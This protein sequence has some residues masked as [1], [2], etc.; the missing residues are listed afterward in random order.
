MTIFLTQGVYSINVSASFPLQSDYIPTITLYFLLSVLYTFLSLAW[1][2]IAE[3][4]KKQKNL[5]FLLEKMIIF[6]RNVLTL[7]KIKSITSNKVIIVQEAVV[8]KNDSNLLKNSCGKCETCNKCSE[9]KKAEEILNKAIQENES[10]INFLNYFVFSLVLISQLI[11][12]LIIWISLSLNS[13]K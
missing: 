3:F 9:E 11:T 12:Y 13:V 4:L 2:V 1:F 10:K 6:F 5:P 7:K 8:K